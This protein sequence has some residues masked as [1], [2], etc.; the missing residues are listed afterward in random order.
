[1]AGYFFPSHKVDGEASVTVQHSRYILF[2]P[3][4]SVCIEDE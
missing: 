4:N 1:M 2:I 3:T